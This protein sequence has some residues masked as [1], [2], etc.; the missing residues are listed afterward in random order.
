MISVLKK[1]PSLIFFGI[2]TLFFT[3]PG[4]TFIVSL[5]VP[6]MRDYFHLS[7]S[8][9]AL[10]YSVATLLTAF[11]VPYMGNLLDRW[12]LRKVTLLAAGIMA[13]GLA[14]LGLSQAVWMVFVGYFLIRTCGQGTLA[15]I[16]STTMAKYFGNLRGKALAWSALG[17]PASEGLMPI[18]VSAVI[19]AIGWR[20]GWIFLLG[21]TVLIYIPMALF[22][23]NAALK[24][25]DCE[26]QLSELRAPPSSGYEV[27]VRILRDPAFYLVVLSSVFPASLITGIFFHQLT[28]IGQKGWT[29]VDLTHA[30]ILFALCRAT[31]ALLTGHWVDRFSALKIFPYIFLPFSFALLSF[32]FGLSVPF[33][34]IYLAGVGLCFGMSNVIIGAVW[35]EI[36]GTENLGTIRGITAGV[37]VVTSAVAPV[38]VGFGLDWGWG[39]VQILNVGLLGCG[40]SVGMA[41]VGTR[42]TSRT[43]PLPVLD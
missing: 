26:A 40:V 25:P 16:S 3:G 24:D 18:V 34:Y 17:Y 14:M 12:D 20:G 28:L 5:F 2:L 21:L 23:L 10:L 13:M 43:N 27:Q 32:R 9:I 38:V 7:Q 22:L 35:A 8:A 6:H 39:L 36:Y 4:Q 33:L 37:M 19:A 11:S 1:Y 31:M 42:K 30:F 29:Q 41:V 15:L